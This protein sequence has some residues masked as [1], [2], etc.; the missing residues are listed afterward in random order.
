MKSISVILADDHRVFLEGMEAMFK[1][2]P[3][4]EVVG[5]A[6]HGE[7][8]L[9]LLR[10]VPAQVVVLDIGM[11]GMDGVATTRK[12]LAHHR[13]VAILILSMHGEHAYVRNLR[14]IGVHGYLLKEDDKSE[15]EAAIKALAYGREYFS[16]KVTEIARA[17][18]PAAGPESD[19]KFTKRESEV[20][21]GLAE[22]WDNQR[23]ADEMCVENS[24]IETHL[25]KIR[26][27]LDLSSA[28][29]LVKWA[30]DHGYGWKKGVQQ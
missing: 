11:P 18:P 24:T 23:I 30:I 15:L 5:T 22:G 21:N 29:A 16:R 10:T 1:N 13:D 14:E 6:T 3:D 19:V 26:F 27:K 12:I 8:V 4:I 7:Q 25:K 9:S 28:R 17:I 2:H 20:M